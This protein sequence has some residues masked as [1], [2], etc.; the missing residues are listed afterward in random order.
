M[1]SW[2]CHTNLVILIWQCD[3]CGELLRWRWNTFQNNDL[4]R[5]CHICITK[6]VTGKFHTQNNIVTISVYLMAIPKNH[7]Q[8]LFNQLWKWY[9]ER[10][11]EIWLGR[12]SNKTRLD[13][14]ISFKKLKIYVW[15]RKLYFSF[16]QICSVFTWT[17][18]T[19]KQT[20]KNVLGKVYLSP[21]H[22]NFGL[23]TII[24][25]INLYFYLYLS[26]SDIILLC[27]KFVFINYSC[28]M[29]EFK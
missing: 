11:Q 21:G 12:K 16:N 3:K 7:E 6:V 2:H 28:I 15:S 18:D 25:A 20:E 14:S 27:L 26:I 9:E 1:D 17:V 19:S 22:W 8:M 4:Q 24:K 13:I 23:A 10:G 5:R 29:A